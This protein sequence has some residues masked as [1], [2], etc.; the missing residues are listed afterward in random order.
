MPSP[1]TDSIASEP[2]ADGTCTLNDG[3][4]IAYN[5]SGAM[6][7]YPVF[8][9]H[10]WPGSRTEGSLFDLQ[11]AELG[12]RIIAIDRPGIGLSTPHSQR[13]VLDHALDIRQVA[14]HLSIKEYSV[15]GVSG[16]G[17]YALACA[18]LIPPEELR[19]VA[20]VCG[21]GPVEVSL[22]GMK[23]GNQMVVRGFQYFPTLILLL[24][25]GTS[26]IL[27]V[28]TMNRTSNERIFETFQTLNR[29]SLLGLVE[30]D[31]QVF[32]KPDTLLVVI[33][34]VREHFRQ[35][36]EGCLAEGRVTTSTLGF[37]I[38]DIK[39]NVRLWY[40]RKDTDVPATIGEEIARQLGKNATL[41]LED[42]SHLSL[43]INQQRPILQDLLR[44]A[45]R[46][47]LLQ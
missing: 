1:I 44:S 12:V 42:E 2:I 8:H 21:Q 9:L 40:G 7:G 45:M 33:T 14:K 3:R 10:G 20:L 31:R 22:R 23:W 6:H 16:G 36:V 24:M 26:W 5:F 4:R 18:F 15:M 17:Q 29:W 41:R 19:S 47:S 39:R 13:T 35:G 11:A 27:K 30:K 32:A 46:R 34:S 38:Q 28:S 37:E 43:V 25:H